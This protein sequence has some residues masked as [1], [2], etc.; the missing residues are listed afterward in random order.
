MSMSRRHVVTPPCHRLVKK[1]GLGTFPYIVTPLFNGDSVVPYFTVAWADGR[2][3]RAWLL[4]PEYTGAVAKIRL[5]SVPMSLGCA[6]APQKAVIETNVAAIG[7]ALPQSSPVLLLVYNSCAGATWRLGCSE[8][9]ANK[10]TYAEVSTPDVCLADPAS[11]SW[12]YLSSVNPLQ[13]LL[14]SGTRMVC[15]T[16]NERVL[17]A[18]PTLSADVFELA[19]REPAS[20]E[21]FD[22]DLT[23]VL[24][25]A[26]VACDRVVDSL[27]ATVNPCCTNGA[28]GANF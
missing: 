24:D 14:S 15:T 18:L 21:G 11:I 22:V 8:D 7:A 26:C 17:R 10:L 19:W 28:G 3:R 2:R 23:A 20:P 6:G 12:F 1:R 27:E 5:E 25:A 9:S 16:R 4:P 13:A